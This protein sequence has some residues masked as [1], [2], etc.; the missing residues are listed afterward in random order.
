MNKLRRLFAPAVL[1]TALAALLFAATAAAETRSGETTSPAKAGIPAE[2]DILGASVSYDST[3]GVANFAVTTAA[4]PQKEVGGEESEL[5]MI[6][7][8]GSPVNG[9]CGLEEVDLPVMDIYSPYAEPI[10]YLLAVENEGENP[11]EGTP[12]TGVKSVIGTKTTL[13]GASKKTANKAYACAVVAVIEGGLGG[14]PIDELSFPVS[15]PPAPTP[16]VTPTAPQSAPAAL[17]LGTVKPLKAKPG[18]WT[19]AKLTVTNTGGTAV[20]PV[21]IKASAPKGVVVKSA[22]TNLPALLPGQSWTVTVDVELTA[23]ARKNS[24]IS[25][26]TSSGGLSAKTSF[27]V[28]LLAG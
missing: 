3:T 2:A 16:A 23:K 28:K 26:T 24:T 15:V 4:E 19:K 12:P 6:A 14:E 20:G 5:D 8:L 7:G 11:F 18:K 22:T 1:I 27:A 9:A 21:A 25:L 17:S 13:V 10:A